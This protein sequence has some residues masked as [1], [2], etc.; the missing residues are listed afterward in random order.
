[1]RVAKNYT[2]GLVLPILL[3]CTLISAYTIGYSDV[4]AKVREATSNDPW[5]P[6]GSQMNELAQMTYNQ[7]VSI[8]FNYS[9][10]LKIYQKRLC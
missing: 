10:Q 5:G 2:K 8:S 3:E 4:Q 1:M 6:S 7:S 9:A